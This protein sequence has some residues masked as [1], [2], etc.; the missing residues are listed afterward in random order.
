VSIAIATVSIITK[1]ARWPWY[2]A[3]V[4]GVAGVLTTAKA[5]I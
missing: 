1:G 3:L 5:Y 2:A 4:L